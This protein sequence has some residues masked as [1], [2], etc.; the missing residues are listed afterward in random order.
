V[1]EVCYGAP[2]PVASFVLDLDRFDGA[3][4]GELEELERRPTV[5]VGAVAGVCEGAALAAAFAV[6]LLVAGPRARFGRAG[7]SSDI[8]VRRGAGIAGR[9]VVAYLTMTSRTIDA[10]LAQTWGI[11]SRLS[12]DPLAA[13]VALAD[14]LATR[15]PRAVAT[16]LRQA[17]AGAAADYALA[18]SIAA[19]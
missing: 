16:I 4:L 3:R 2:W 1:A 18:R 6:D 15:S 8:V 10:E 13:A 9:K 17:H 19:R 7:D 14:E 5:V 11:V 12:D